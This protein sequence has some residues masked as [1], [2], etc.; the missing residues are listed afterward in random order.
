M[1]IR[2]AVLAGGLGG[3]RCVDALARAAGPEAVTAIVNVGDDLEAFG[4]H[5]SPDL[6]TV[7]YTLAGL[8]DEQR[9][10]GIRDD[11]TDALAIV[12]RLGGSTW[13]TLGDRDL[14]VHLVR[15]ELLRH[16]HPLSFVSSRL[17]EALGVRTPLLPATDDRLRTWISTPDGELPFQEWY[18]HRRHADRVLGVRFEGADEAQPAPGVL[19]AI[20]SADLVIIAPS[21]PYVSIFPILAVREIRNAVAARGAVAISPI[22]DGKALRGPLAEMMQDQGVGASPAGIA[23]LYDGLATRI[24]LDPADA[25]QAEDIPGAVICPIV[26]ADPDQRAEVGRQLLEALL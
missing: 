18:V 16:G 2:I 10:W 1:S 20:A 9:G 4:L 17:A 7:L 13:F 14:G 3:S 26:M 5:V 23:A 15:T 12:G 24:V 22:I 21:N 25:A 8:L 11:T 6:D 19:E